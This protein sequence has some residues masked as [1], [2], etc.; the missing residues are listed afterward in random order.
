MYKI[1]W[2]HIPEDNN[3]ENFIMFIGTANM[4]GG[5]GGALSGK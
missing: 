3:L 4:P 5:G 2:W 1:T